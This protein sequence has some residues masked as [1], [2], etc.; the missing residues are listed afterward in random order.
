MALQ[1]LLGELS[2][3]TTQ[4]ELLGGVLVLLS[5]ILEK[6]PRVD[7]ADRM[8]VSHSES[9]PAV[10]IASAQTLATLTTLGNQTN[11]GGRDASHMAYAAANAG[12]MHI[13]NNL[14]FS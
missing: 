6:M 4:Q 2:N 14:I 11:V 13:Y 8:V 3:E 12:S 10:T 9:S 5:S 7:G 1:N